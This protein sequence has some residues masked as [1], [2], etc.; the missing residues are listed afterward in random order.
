MTY[1]IVSTGHRIERLLVD[2]VHTH[3]P[4]HLFSLFIYKSRSSSV[5]STPSIALALIMAAASVPG[6]VSFDTG[7]LHILSQVVNKMKKSATN[8]T[9]PL[10]ATETIAAISEHMY[11]LR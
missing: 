3:Q 4:L 8:R 7:A 2:P 5:I 9:G 10:G 11:V 6:A 1:G